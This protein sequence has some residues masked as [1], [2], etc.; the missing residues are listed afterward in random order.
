[1]NP[2]DT[3]DIATLREKIVNYTNGD[4]VFRPEFLKGIILYGAE[5]S[6]INL[7]IESR[8]LDE[9]GNTWI[10]FQPASEKEVPLPPGPYRVQNG[11]LF[12]VWRLYSD[13]KLAFLQSVWPSKGSSGYVVLRC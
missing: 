13:N 6:Q 1:V 8:E 2:G 10:Q 5:R 11:A 12:E 4:D 7:Q 9:L 3:L